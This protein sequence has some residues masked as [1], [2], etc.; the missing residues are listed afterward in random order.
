LARV[1]DTAMTHFQAILFFA[2]VISVAF[3]FMTKRGRRE[4]LLYALWSFLGFV[5][6]AVAIGWLLFPFPR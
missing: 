2:V 5:L 6:I 3:A 4:R 1:S